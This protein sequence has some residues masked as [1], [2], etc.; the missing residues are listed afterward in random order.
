MKLREAPQ[1]FV[2]LRE[3]RG[4]ARFH[5]ALQSSARL[6]EAPG[7]SARFR[8]ISRDFARPREATRGVARSS[9]GS[10]RFP[11]SPRGSTRLREAP[12]GILRARRS[13]VRLRMEEE[14]PGIGRRRKWSV[15]AQDLR[16]V[17][18]PFKETAGHSK[19]IL[20][21]SWNVM[22]PNLIM[23]CGKERS[24]SPDR[25]P[26]PPVARACIA[27]I[28]SLCAACLVSVASA[29]VGENPPAALPGPHQSDGSLVVGR[30]GWAPRCGCTKRSLSALHMSRESSGSCV[31]T[32]GRPQGIQAC[33]S[34][35]A[36]GDALAMVSLAPVAERAGVGH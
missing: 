20:G 3:A 16:N 21:I 12:H 4:S 8:E 17:K 23:S 11:E 30:S 26:D 2:R 35:P 13:A 25:R 19:G 18:Y 14:R 29:I 31:C 22:D 10:M 24:P 36:I 33:A 28:V 5:E 7:G 27:E 32:C 15:A 1:G 34:A 6:R 9:R